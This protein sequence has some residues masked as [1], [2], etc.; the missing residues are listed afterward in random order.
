MSNEP[1]PAQGPVDV[2]VSR[3]L[4]LRADSGCTSFTDTCRCCELSTRLGVGVVCEILGRDRYFTPNM[5][6]HHVYD[7]NNDLIGEE[8]LNT[9]TAYASS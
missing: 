9:K 8:L 3:Q 2:N 6:P 4:Y 1:L 7:F 5:N